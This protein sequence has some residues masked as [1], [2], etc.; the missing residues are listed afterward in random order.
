MGPRR[1][2]IGLRRGRLER[3]LSHVFPFT[4][5]GSNQ[6]KGKKSCQPD[7]SPDPAPGFFDNPPDWTCERCPGL[8]C[9]SLFTSNS[10]LPARSLGLLNAM[11]YCK[12]RAGIH[13]RARLWRGG[14][15]AEGG[16]L[17][18]RCTC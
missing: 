4:I 7:R 3:S 5:L 13:L 10:M 6:H 18:N 12:N 15:E 14:R 11:V 1:R 8:A 9:R 2:Q 17:L 16:G